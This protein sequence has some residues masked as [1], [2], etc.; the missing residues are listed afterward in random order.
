MNRILGCFYTTEKETIKI[1][2]M[3]S[4]AG[5]PDYTPQRT[6]S[7]AAGT[8]VSLQPKHLHL[9][10]VYKLEHLQEAKYGQVSSE[11]KLSSIHQQGSRC[12]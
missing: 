3:G 8:V 6:F 11:K 2:S 12:E 4:G 5:L 1:V 9:T 7:A 10:G